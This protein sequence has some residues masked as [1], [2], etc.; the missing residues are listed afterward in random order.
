M[1]QNKI[2]HFYKPI[3]FFIKRRIN[4]SLDAED[5]TQEV[6]YKIAKSKEDDIR[7]VKSWIYSIAKHAII[8][9]YRMQ[10]KDINEVVEFTDEEIENES[11]LELSQCIV[12][13]IAR[14]PDKYKKVI[15]LS[16]IEGMSQK[17][18]AKLLDINY[19][20]VRSIVQ[21]GRTKLKMLISECC[22]IKQGGKGS[23][24]EFNKIDGCS[25]DC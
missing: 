2:D 6:F 20:T 11:I 10:K 3:L 15:T 19:I 17:Q 21:R 16:E 5:L 8:D 13:F 12:P 24:L 22:N 14:L 7:N 25:E 9:Y 23:I 4:N 18:I 1:N